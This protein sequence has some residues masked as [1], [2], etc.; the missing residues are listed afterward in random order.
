MVNDSA[1]AH[2]FLQTAARVRLGDG[3]ADFD[4]CANSDAVFRCFRE[5]DADRRAAIRPAVMEMSRGMREYSLHADA[6]G[7][8]RLQSLQELERYCHYVAGTVG[9]LLTSLF[10]LQVPGLPEHVRAQLRARAISF[11]LA[12]QF[13]NI[14]KDVAEDFPRGDCFLPAELAA[15]HN[16]SLDDI[17]DPEQR[18]AA[19]GVVRAGVRPCPR[20]S[21]P[22]PRVHLV[23][24]R[25][26][27]PQRAPCS[28]LCR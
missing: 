20:A 10:E 1:S 16:I 12:L 4:L 6:H 15:E 3:S 24:A 7:K 9:K 11:G 18:E 27:R 22:R 21:A 2:A 5:F 25:G 14:V 26:R 17:L 23:M 13:V 8:L 28:A 19:L